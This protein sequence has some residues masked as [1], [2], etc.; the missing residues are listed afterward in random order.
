VVALIGGGL[1]YYELRSPNWYA[2]G[3]T[4]EQHND[5]LLTGPVSTLP[6]TCTARMN[7]ADPGQRP[8][9]TDQVSVQ[10]WLLGCE[11]AYHQQHPGQ[12]VEDGIMWPSG[13]KPCARAC[14]SQWSA[15]GKRIAL[16]ASEE[17]L[18]NS[19]SAAADWCADL[20]AD[21]FIQPIPASIEARLHAHVPAAGPQAYSWDQGCAA[22]YNAMAANGGPAQPNAPV[23]VT[24]A[25]G[26]SPDLTIPETAPPASLYTTTLSTRAPARR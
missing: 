25:F 13:T 19:K 1:A 3:Q 26:A 7:A 22:Q 21:R 4:A 12:L 11:A 5:A 8:A 6:A 15:A 20:A 9:K 18:I 17:P 14:S 2:D 10:Q 23:N 16:A 24:G